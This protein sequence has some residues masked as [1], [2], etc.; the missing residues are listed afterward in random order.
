MKLI[1]SRMLQ[2]VYVLALLSIVTFALMKLAP[3]DPVLSMLRVDEV[4]VTEADE[5]ALREELGLDRPLVLQYAEWVWRLVQLDLGD[6]YFKG[7]PVLEVLAERLPA[8]LQLTAG[9]LL[10]MLATALPLGALS[11]AYAGRLPDHLSRILAL[12]GSSMPTFWVG[13]LF[14][15]LFG[16]KLSWLPTMGMGTP[17]HLILPC[18]TFGLGLATI[19]ARLL[20]AGLL[21]VLSQ[22]YIRAARARGLSEWRVMTRYAMRAALAPVLTIFGMSIGSLLA[23]SV[24]VETLFSWPGIGNMA[25]EAIFHRDY[26]LIQGYVLLT[27]MFVVVVNLAVD[28]LYGLLDPRVRHARGELQ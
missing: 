8:T 22:E 28:L 23:G 14:I 10:V 3:G 11:A 19:Y 18:L 12:I 24:V 20:R 25:V 2:L 4:T 7:K 5:A 17:Q 1:G 21:E 15:Y 13:L 16:Y 26:P 6:S 27:G 9:S